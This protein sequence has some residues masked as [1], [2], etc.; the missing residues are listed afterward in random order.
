[1]DELSLLM[2]F[3]VLIVICIIWIIISE[4]NRKNVK[5]DVQWFSDVMKQDNID[6]EKDGA[7]VL[8][9]STINDFLLY[10]N[11]EYVYFVN[12][13]N[14]KLQ[15]VY[16]KDVLNVEVEVYRYEK[17]VKRLVALTSTFDK[18]VIIGD[19]VLKIT[20][21]ETTCN[22]FCMINGKDGAN[23]VFTNR[24]IAVDDANR[25]K[26]M[27]EDDVKKIKEMNI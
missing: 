18:N 26:L 11:R 27:I 20:T 15:K 8:G 10:T 14:R 12:L 9:Q 16:K 23:R 21:R 19:V 3:G 24:M 6:D 1:M 5:T 22:V 4:K 17:N 25:V 7:L 2:F 13:R